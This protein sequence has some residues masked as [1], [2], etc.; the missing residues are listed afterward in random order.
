MNNVTLYSLS[1]TKK[2]KVWKASTDYS[3]TPD[4]GIE[5]I[6]QWG[7]ED[8][9]QQTKSIFVKSGKNIGK[10]NETSIVEQADL[11]LTY[12][13]TAQ[14]E[15]AYFKTKEEYVEPKGP[16]LA[17]KYKDKKHTI[18]W[19]KNRYF[20]SKKLN[21]IR[22]FIHV[23][24]GKVTH[25][26]SRSSKNF[27]YFTHLAEQLEKVVTND[28]TCIFDGE[29]FNPEIP[30]EVISTLVNSDDY[31][32]DSGYK[33]EDIHFYCYDYIDS[34]NPD[35]NFFDRFHDYLALYTIFL[36]TTCFHV[37]GNIQVKSEQEMIDLANTWISEGHEGL[38]LRD[39]EA[40]YVYS[41]RSI[42]LLKYKVMEQ[43]E[44]LIKDIYLAEN[45]PTKVQIVCYNHFNPTDPLYNSFDIG[46][47]KGNK[48]D[49]I[50]NY[51]SKK[52]ELID[53]MYLTVDYQTLSKYN[54]PLFPVGIALRKGYRDKDNN[55]VAEV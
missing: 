25:F 10:K 18:K 51:F 16:M 9:K 13:Y 28:T 8:G 22:C 35:S 19:D 32:E 14:F 44:F 48:E 52:E 46:S 55:F 39:G 42:A 26:E 2:W 5:I 31:V 37:V 1:K 23:L 49:N 7:Y 33:T 11:K 27:K 20:A 34:K 50:K 45:D 12:L 21:G 3:I 24:N 38:M 43:D 36:N 40:P 30:F 15:D 4:K 47:L 41:E 54:V 29:L 53:K 6:I 17:H